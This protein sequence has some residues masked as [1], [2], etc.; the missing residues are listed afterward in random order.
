MLK[1]RE[2]KKQKQKQKDTDMFVRQTDYTTKVLEI[3]LYLHNRKV[4]TL[5]RLNFAVK[6]LYLT[7]HCM[8]DKVDPLFAG[9]F[10]CCLEQP[11]S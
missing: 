5:S 6:I 7:S 8:E 10:C 2:K 1:S 9:L 4:V 11:A 3:T